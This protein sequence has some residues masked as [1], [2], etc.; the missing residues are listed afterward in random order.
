VASTSC[1]ETK[2]VLFFLII[3]ECRYLGLLHV[4]LAPMLMHSSQAAGDGLTRN[5]GGLLKNVTGTDR[6]NN[7]SQKAHIHGDSNKSSILWEVSPK[8]IR[9][10]YMVV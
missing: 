7:S 5:V 4:I 2:I 1:N 8:G 6:I 3:P 10:Y 9:E